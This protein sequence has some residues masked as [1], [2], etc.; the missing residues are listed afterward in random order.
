MLCD[1]VRRV[2][3]FFLDGSLGERKLTDVR[4]HLHDC[5]DCE[6]RVRIH[7]SLRRFVRSRLVQVGAPEHLRLRLTQ[8]IR[9]A[10]AE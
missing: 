4:T 2:A 8:S 3:Y 10:G 7:T 9:A 6:T 5:P 1:E